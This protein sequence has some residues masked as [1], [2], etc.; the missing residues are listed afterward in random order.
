M[1]LG[2]CQKCP[3]GFI[4]RPSGRFEPLKTL[5]LVEKIKTETRSPSPARTVGVLGRARSP[6]V[7]GPRALPAA[8]LAP[9]PL[10]WGSA[11]SS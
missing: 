4:L 7:R 2:A 3:L 1:R 10:P 5:S 11:S 6:T 8:P 9:G